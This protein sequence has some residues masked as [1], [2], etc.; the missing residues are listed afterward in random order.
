MKNR[1]ITEPEFLAII[2][3][4]YQEAKRRLKPQLDGLNR[5]FVRFT[6]MNKEVRIGGQCWHFRKWIEINPCYRDKSDMP[7]WSRENFR[8]TVRHEICHLKNPS[9]GNNFL[10][11]LKLLQGHRYVGAAVYE[12]TKPKKK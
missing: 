7:K 12:G 3:E 4:E 6:W 8:M 2:N 10:I 9:H 1:K 5:S 11:A